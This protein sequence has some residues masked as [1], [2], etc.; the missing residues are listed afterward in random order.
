MKLSRTLA[1]AL[2]PY[3]NDAVIEER[4][5]SAEPIVSVPPYID[6]QAEEHNV[7]S[8]AVVP[9]SF[10]KGLDAQRDNLRATV[11]VER[12]DDGSLATWTAK[13]VE[14][15]PE[16]H[17]RWLTEV[18]VDAR[19]DGSAFVAVR[20]ATSQDGED[21]KRRHVQHSQPKCVANIVKRTDL[22]CRRGGVKLG[23]EPK[24]VD[25]TTPAEFEAFLLE[26]ADTARTVPLVVVNSN[27]SGKYPLSDGAISRLAERLCGVAAVCLVPWTDDG[28]NNRF[29]NGLAELTDLRTLA[30]QRGEI[31][32]Y[33][34]VHADGEGENA[35]KL[36]IVQ[37]RSESKT[38]Q[39]VMNAVVNRT[40]A[41]PNVERAAFHATGTTD[42]TEQ[43]EQE[44]APAVEQ[45]AILARE[46]KTASSPEG[47]GANALDIVQME[48]NILKECFKNFDEAFMSLK[49]SDLA[50]TVCADSQMAGL[51]ADS[52]DLERANLE[53]EEQVSGALRNER[54]AMAKAQ[55]YEQLYSE[56][57]S[58]RDAF[59]RKINAM[60]D[61]E[62]IPTNMKEVVD[63]AK[64]MFADHLV[65][66]PKAERSAEDDSTGGYCEAWRILRALDHDLWP[67]CFD[68]DDR[69]AARIADD[70]KLRT[71][72]ELTLSE[73]S[74][75]KASQR[76]RTQR[77]IRYN[78]KTL[79][80]E[81][82]VKGT[83]GSKSNRLRIYFAI[84]RDER[85]IVIG[86]CGNHLET[87]GTKRKE[88]Q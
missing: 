87:I 36:L 26:I 77:T 42:A 55:H 81:P 18:R 1:C 25:L 85:K 17:D 50:N 19:A 59:E 2:A 70:F 73:S 86:H 82:H 41:R 69:P 53:L 44:S 6:L 58:E 74:N 51:M 4:S 66:V 67:M 33:L 62:A 64:S 8:S 21:A 7:P 49:A 12:A 56:T 43:E 57:K 13:L 38:V 75:T 63:L 76:C 83:S 15:R 68:R 16:K 23:S 40:N 5:E 37:D 39:R 22:V 48:Y 65:F 84:D 34:G 32:V 27:G 24:Q 29:K 78:N 46:D 71:G 14:L 60:N 28:L 11:E 47:L 54:E 52:R 88:L 20:N 45:D 30:P 10:A 35:H 72:F 80:I 79:S 31:N 9:A 61:L 3:V